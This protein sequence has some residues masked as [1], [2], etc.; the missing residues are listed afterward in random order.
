MTSNT[1]NTTNTITRTGG[2]HRMSQVV[3]HDNTL[4]LAGQVADKVDVGI[5]GQT[6]EVLAKIDRLLAAHG[7]HKERILSCQIYLADMRHFA[8]MNAV[9]DQWV[10]P[11]HAPARATL[12][13]RLASPARLIEICVVA[14]AELNG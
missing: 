14:S 11:G 3:R 2:N 5:G 12:E 13:A 4:Y 10:T 8:E 1:N 6:E 7:S 9:W